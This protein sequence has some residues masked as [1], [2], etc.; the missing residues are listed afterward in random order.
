MKRV[1]TA[2]VFILI[3][4]AICLTGY[5]VCVTKLNSINDAL[6]K[7]T[8]VVKTEDRDKILDTAKNIENEWEKSS[9][10]L[11]AILSHS[12]INEISSNIN[13]L[14]F[15]AQI[16]DYDEFEKLCK[17]SIIISEHIIATQSASLKNIL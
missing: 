4:I 14:T 1:I 13:M 11:Y 9:A 2:V 6:G 3:A 15:F 8:Y 12:D 10:L 5:A 7:A 17:E 16:E